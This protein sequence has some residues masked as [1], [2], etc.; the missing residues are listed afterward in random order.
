MKPFARLLD[1]MGK[2]A[3]S[4]LNKVTNWYGTVR[5]RRKA[6]QAKQSFKP[7]NTVEFNDLIQRHNSQTK[8][9]EASFKQHKLD[10]NTHYA[11]LH[12]A[13]NEQVENCDKQI[14]AFAETLAEQTLDEQ[15]NPVTLDSFNNDFSAHYTR[16][17][18]MMKEAAEQANTQQRKL[19]RD[20]DEMTVSGEKEQPKP[21]K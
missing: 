11:Q 15:G 8:E 6:E 18:K 5:Q 3:K 17:S 4:F 14:L 21:K 7:E 1:T 13:F 16:L 19:E 9:I 10:A 12:A 20:I 2:K